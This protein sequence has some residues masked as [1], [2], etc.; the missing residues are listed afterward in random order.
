MEEWPAPVKLWD[1]RLFRISP[2]RLSPGQGLVARLRLL[3]RFA[4]SALHGLMPRLGL[5]LRD[6]SPPAN[7]C[8]RGLVSFCW[9]RE[10]GGADGGRLRAGR[11]GGGDSQAGLLSILSFTYSHAR[12]V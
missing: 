2:I 9:A 4:S 6:E 3:A 5:E 8:V 1:A 7:A 10:E 11:R 12:A